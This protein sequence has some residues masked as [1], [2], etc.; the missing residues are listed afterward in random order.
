MAG[1]RGAGAAWGRLLG[2]VPAAFARRSLRSGMHSAARGAALRDVGVV[3]HDDVDV[4]VAVVKVR[5]DVVEPAR[6][7]SPV[8]A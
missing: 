3:I 4:V 8:G 7:R 1:A 6:S 2:P 5:V